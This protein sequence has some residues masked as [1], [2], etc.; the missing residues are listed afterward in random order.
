M[1]ARTPF[2]VRS[3]PTLLPLAARAAAGAILGGG[4]L[5]CGLA[6]L[7]D[8]PPARLAEI[9]SAPA[10]LE[11]RLLAAA[12]A[13]ASGGILSAAAIDAL[14]RVLARALRRSRIR[15]AEGRAALIWIAENEAAVRLAT[16]EETFLFHVEPRGIE[17]LIEAI[18]VDPDVVARWLDLPA[19]AGGCW[20]LSL[21]RPAA[22]RRAA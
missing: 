1:E 2:F 18:E 17:R 20:L 15:S 13:L 8:H 3:A 22:R 4:L 6:L 9:R 10:L 5:G 19:P 21:E 16:G 7:G 11:P 14:R 12:A